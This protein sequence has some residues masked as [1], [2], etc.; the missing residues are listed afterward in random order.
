MSDFPGNVPVESARA[1]GP[2][3]MARASALLA[4]GTFVSRALGFVSALVLAQTIGII[5]AGADT[6]TLANQLPNNIYAL[7]AGGLLNA[8]LVPQIVRAG[9]HD[10][11]GAKFINR[12]VTLGA[13]LFL[14]AAAITVV[15]APL[16]V[17][18]YA[19]SGTHGFDGQEL[20]LATAFAYWCLPQVLFYAL[21]SLVGEV[22]NARGVFGPY[23]WAPALN[24]VVAIA[25]MLAFL[26]MFGGAAQHRSATDWTPGMVA[27]L[28]GSAT[29]GIAVQ[30]CV[31]FF[32]WK[33][34]G[35]SYRPEFRWH[36][37]GLGRTGKVAAWTF[38]M[39]L[40]SQLAGIIEMNVA[41]LASGDASVA[42]LRYAWL[43]FMLPHSIF[44]ISIAT[45]YFT[46]MSVS[47][48][49]G[50]LPAVR[51][52][53]SAS[54]R[55]ILL[56]MVFSTAALLVL[57]FPF[58]AVFGGEYQQVL[59]LGSVL[60]AFLPGLIP[61]SILFVLQRAFY[62]LED[63]RT[64][65]FIQLV[66]AALFVTGCFIAASL[67]QDLIAVGLALALTTAGTLQTV[68]AA[69]LLRR[70]LGGLG[71]RAILRELLWM[72]LAAIPT[73]VA[74]L[75]IIYAL[76]WVGAGAFPVSGFFGAVVTLA[77]S[78]AGMVVVYVAVLSA[79]KNKELGALAGPIVARFR[80]S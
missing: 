77:L 49:D 66:Q 2:A 23:T 60:L 13:V 56:V 33:R 51:R 63:T 75:G 5:G 53:I 22:L 74:G 47:A 43:V 28:G 1:G 8:V 59:A 15:C 18:L 7:I 78:G 39:I 10:D 38:G 42:V 65:F 3:A 35:L 70:R 50:D 34:A 32:F 40:V 73:A 80:K 30:A 6:F 29:L 24:N 44:A 57:A 16:L 79:F 54:L 67:P 71:S 55:S 46:R 9:L 26:A 11:G 4:S 64:P 45:P 20:A 21:Y 68:L 14:A 27:L 36:G 62:S 48:R 52:D 61:F 58:A 12:I 31:L 37:V 76:G 25:G 72:L 69:F 41:T 17:R 19:Q